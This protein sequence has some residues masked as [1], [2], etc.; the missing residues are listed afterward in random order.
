LNI[1]SLIL[2]SFVGFG[3]NEGIRRQ[4]L[5][6]FRQSRRMRQEPVTPERLPFAELM[7]ATK[8]T[9][10]AA[11]AMLAWLEAHADVDQRPASAVRELATRQLGCGTTLM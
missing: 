2:P 1:W 8:G 10:N 3:P 9:R 5:I 6:G 4:R 11:L 7:P